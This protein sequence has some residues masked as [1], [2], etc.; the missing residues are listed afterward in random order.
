MDW[1]DRLVSAV[2]AMN[3]MDQLVESMAGGYVPTIY[4]DSRR[5]RLLTRVLLALGWS[6]FDGWET[7]SR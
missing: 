5:K 7:V 2:T 1:L 3:T 4:P 6:V